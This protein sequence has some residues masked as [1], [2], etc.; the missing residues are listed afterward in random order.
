MLSVGIP[1]TT[2][3]LLSIHY[4]QTHAEYYRQLEVSHEL[5]DGNCSFM[6]YALQGFI[7]GLKE[8]INLVKLQ[9]LS[10]HW[11]NYVHDMFR[12]NNSPADVRQCRLVLDLSKDEKPVPISKIKRIS[13]RIAEAYANKTYKTVTRDI[14]ALVTMG[15]VEKKGKEI[16]QAFLTQTINES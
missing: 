5:K 2:V 6:K 7:D 4:N 9:Q 13:A 1:A 14:N 12:D 8:Q 15:L 10:V 11:T 16:I 3:H